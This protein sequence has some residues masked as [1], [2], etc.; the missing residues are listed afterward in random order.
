MAYTLC[1]GENEEPCAYLDAYQW[2][3][4]LTE[5]G[6]EYFGF[7]VDDYKALARG[8][9][10]EAKRSYLEALKEEPAVI[11]KGLMQ[12]RADHLSVLA[13]EKP[14]QKGYSLITNTLT[15]NLLSADTSKML[16]EEMA[17]DKA[18]NPLAVHVGGFSP[19]S[20]WVYYYVEGMPY[21]GTMLVNPSNGGFI[22]DD[23]LYI[24]ENPREAAFKNIRR[25]IDKTG[26]KL[27]V[28]VSR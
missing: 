22:H 28:S 7:Y 20:P 26:T 18:S 11:T 3:V 27:R 25:T 8:D 24:H 9:A 5:I 12:L 15:A 13:F 14:G 4:T 16:R 6:G 23:F 17:E 21:V 1:R 2:K 10:A 19:Q